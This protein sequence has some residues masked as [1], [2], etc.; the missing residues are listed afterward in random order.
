MNFFTLSGYWK[1]LDSLE[2]YSHAW[3]SMGDSAFQFLQFKNSGF[4]FGQ[5]EKPSQWRQLVV[6][7]T[8]LSC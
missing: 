4:M 2:G 8:D 3:E 5:T 6:D 7:P 1:P